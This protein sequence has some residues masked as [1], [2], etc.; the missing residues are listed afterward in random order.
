[1]TLNE[2]GKIVQSWGKYLE[3]AH[4]KLMC[5]FGES[6]PESFLPFPENTLKEALNI[7]A[8]HQRTLGNEEMVKVLQGSF[9][10]L[11]MYENDEEAISKAA[12]LFNDVTWRSTML[13][14]FKKFQETW[15][16]KQGESA[17]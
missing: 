13:P 2:A 6:I 11:A 4:G 8:E 10:V 1:M 17:G 12:R 15:V 14:V 7:L 16:K 5:I 3:Y 9:E